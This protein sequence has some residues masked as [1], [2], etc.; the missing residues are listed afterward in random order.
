MES[1]IEGESQE[2]LSVTPPQS[3]MSS[4]KSL[5]GGSPSPSPAS[6]SLTP[7]RKRPLVDAGAM[8]PPAASPRSPKSAR[9]TSS[10]LFMQEPSKPVPPTPRPKERQFAPSGSA[11]MP[12]LFR[13]NPAAANLLESPNR[14]T[15]E[16][17]QKG[18]LGRGS[19]GSVYLCKNRLDGCLYAIKKQAMLDAESRKR[20]QREVVACATLNHL[21]VHQ[22]VLRYYSVWREG[23]YMY[24][25][26]EYCGG[27]SLK[28]DE[29]YSESRLCD[30]LEQVADGLVFIHG[31]KL[32][33]MDIK[34][35]NIFVSHPAQAVSAGA[36]Q[37]LRLD[38]MIED[39]DAVVYKIGDLGLLTSAKE[40][41]DVEEGDS[42]YMAPELLQ[43]KY[44]NLTAADI[45]SL[46]LT[47]YELARG[48]ELPS[49]GELFR[50][51]RDGKMPPLKGYSAQFNEILQNM[52]HP[53]PDERPKAD[54]LRSMARVARAALE[55]RPAI[56]DAT[57]KTDALKR[58]LYKARVAN[59]ELKS[60]K[61]KPVEA[62]PP[63]RPTTHSKLTKRSQSTYNF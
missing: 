19:F 17:E 12:S 24:M 7:T 14:F 28:L 18:L 32:A 52:A 53:D 41:K 1:L 43:D 63:A 60:A 48:E 3:P 46:G 42:R 50:A 35:E 27:G 20:A 22:N 4:R 33:H 30:L 2:M 49:T 61:L 6:R 51:L 45:F 9:L 37:L 62:A 13:P 15:N 11:S 5:F 10:L 26:N 31:Y 21:G 44:S 57:L 38:S 36:Q 56:D 23:E 47:V 16:F 40:V 54:V 58:D 29:S 8:S 39:R 59:W 34:R 55:N 25:Q